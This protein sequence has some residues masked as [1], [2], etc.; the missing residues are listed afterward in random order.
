MKKQVRTPAKKKSKAS[1][2]PRMAQGL[3]AGRHA[4]PASPVLT[5]AN[6]NGNHKQEEALR[7]SPL[8]DLPT[9]IPKPIKEKA[10]EPAPAPAPERDDQPLE[11]IRDIL[12][13]S[14]MSALD[15]RLAAI[16]SELAELSAALAALNT[17]VT[18]AQKA[19]DE[20]LEHAR[21]SLRMSITNI[22][23]QLK[24][25]AQRI[26]TEALTKAEM[27][28]LLTEMGGLIKQDAHD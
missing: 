16:Q 24:E 14:Q 7:I 13:G 9:P 20:N 22:Q 3:A 18:E 6:G 21:R 25:L 27:A 11:R 8:F 2:A 1:A 23:T 10:A 19:G 15:A 4:P 28:D 17:R 12:F 26:E 5:R